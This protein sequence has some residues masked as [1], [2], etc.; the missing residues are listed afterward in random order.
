[1]KPRL[2]PEDP[3]VQSALADIYR[4]A[5]AVFFRINAD[6]QHERVRVAQLLSELGL[7]E[8]NVNQITKTFPW[9]QL[10]FLTKEKKTSDAP[11]KAKQTPID[12][13]YEDP[14][15]DDEEEIQTNDLKR[16]QRYYLIEQGPYFGTYDGLDG[17]QTL[18]YSRTE[19]EKHLR[20]LLHGKETHNF[21]GGTKA[22]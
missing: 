20:D 18:F 3:A 11:K 17:G 21:Y 16:R 7:A 5:A 2:S 1:M 14:L 22:T 10:Q 19:A 13:E 6:G 8:E 15:D 4:S 9:P 12:L